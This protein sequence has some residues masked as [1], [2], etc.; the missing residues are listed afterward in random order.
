MESPIPVTRTKILVPRRRTEL[1]TRQ[2]LLDSLSELLD[3]KLIIVAAPAGYGKT[4]LLIDFVNKF[5][6]PVC[7]YALDPL[8]RDP[9]RFLSHFIAA[10]N[11]RFP[12]FGQSSLS[13]LNNMSQDR[14]NLDQ[15]VSTIINDAYD[16]IREHFIIVLDDYHLLDES[17]P[18]N[19]FISRFV[20]DIDENCHVV[21][22]SRTLLT[23][24][25]LPLL[26]ARS[27]VGGL[28][29]EELA[30]QPPEVQGLLLQN[31]HMT[32]TDE[33]AA[34]MAQQTEGWITGLLL[35]AQANGNEMGDRTRVA[36]V[37][38]IGLYDYLAQ[39]VFDQQSP[40]LQDFLL[41]TS[42]LEEFDSSL[43]FEVIAKAL[44]LDRDW[45]AMM[46][47]V[48]MRNLFVLPVG[49]DQLYLRYHHLFRDFLQN[50]I[51][52][53]RPKQAEQ[54]QM[55]LAEVYASRR[56]WERAY[57][58]YQRLGQMEAIAN[59]IEQAGVPLMSGGKLVTLNDWMGALPAELLTS[60]PA[61][62]SLEGMLVVMHSDINKGLDLLNQALSAIQPG[63]APF[64]MALTL[65]RR[66]VAYR[67]LGDYQRSL[68][69]AERALVLCDGETVKSLQVQ[70]EAYRAKAMCLYHQGMMKESLSW[71]D[72]SLKSFQA[73]EDDQSVARMLIEMGMVQQA[74][75][76]YEEAELTYTR[77]LEYWQ[78]RDN[79]VWMSNLL[80]NLGGLQHIRGNFESSASTF[81]K[82]IQY[83]RAGSYP[84][85]EGYTLASI[86]ELY[87]DMD[88]TEEA[89]E[90]YRQARQIADKV[91]E[92]SLSFY[93]DIDEAALARQHGHYRHAADLLQAA[94]E[95]GREGGS[96]FEKNLLRLE[97]GALYTIKKSYA[98]A[99]P[100]LKEAAEYFTIEDY[101]IEAAR[102]H[103]FLLAVTFV[104]GQKS[105]AIG[106]LKS[107]FALAPIQNNRVALAVTAREVCPTLEQMGQDNDFNPLVSDLVKLIQQYEQELPSLR[108]HLRRQASS[109]PFAPPRLVIQALG[110]LQVKT[111]DHA[112][113]NTDWQTQEACDL[114]YYLLTHPEGL[115]KEQIGEAFWPESSAAEIKL[116]FK[117]SMYRLRH[118]AGKDIV[119]FN[120]E[121]YFFNHYLDYEYD[122]ETFLREISEAQQSE[123][124]DK[125]AS[126]LRAALKTYKGS[127]LPEVEETWVVLERQRLH[128]IYIDALLELT[129]LYI[130]KRQYE[131]ALKY[132]QHALTQDH[133]LEAAHRLAMR[134]HAAMGN[135]AGVERQYDVCRRAL[136][137]DFNLQP[138]PQT[139]TLYQALTR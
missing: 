99:L 138:S 78:S 43:C 83:A 110:R 70:A 60:R 2:R 23:L 37:S 21:V 54:I 67:L 134:I 25:D 15:M 69:D 12:Q 121:T 8:D 38:G 22:T 111:G 79:F 66:S 98:E 118:A 130:E 31:Y 29:F 131:T 106:H 127:Y 58:V 93:L 77:S 123:S 57:S 119:L 95:S 14:L 34:Q 11:L 9:Q 6:W 39:Q 18:V 40:E 88:A 19:H 124:P 49:E 33:A 89:R 56:D 109:V 45:D 68:A 133:C 86:G 108:R 1:L 114:F 5:E 115:T 102:A 63:Q 135:R 47:T 105:E 27:Q 3:N 16:H 107:V 129:G 24:P 35:S 112:L 65:S 94:E 53:N 26:V 50:R 32:I 62:L 64:Q 75:G 17:K 41:W 28:S 136:Q 80:N 113:T 100:A 76:K 48:T 96:L 126:H 122:V 91:K 92:R 120:D 84:R 72:R 101:K 10:L 82:A 132:C 59:M 90:A 44:K 52:H 7:W 13:A 128:Q 125:K 55:R 73:I 74:L 61:L 30:F 137:D 46:E 20:Q 97:W 51:Q 104:E 85:L 116:R 4:S 71:F 42:L 81:E 87:R 117:N 103:I 139:E 36:K